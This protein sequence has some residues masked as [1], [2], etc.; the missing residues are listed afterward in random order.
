MELEQ[1]PFRAF[2]VSPL[3]AGIP[4][5]ERTNSVAKFTVLKMNTEKQIK[6]SVKKLTRILNGEI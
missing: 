1:Y 4:F 2:R 5:D 6:A 3:C